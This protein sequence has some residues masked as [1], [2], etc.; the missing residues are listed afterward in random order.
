[1][2]RTHLLLMGLVLFLGCRHRPEAHQDE[3]E[4]SG[5]KKRS[6]KASGGIEYKHTLSASGLPKEM[7]FFFTDYPESEDA[8]DQKPARKKALAKL[9]ADIK[10]KKGKDPNP[11]EVGMHVLANTD[12]GFYHLTSG[13]HEFEQEG[14]IKG[15]FI[16]HINRSDD[17]D[18]NLIVTLGKDQGLKPNTRYAITGE[19]EI[20]SNTPTGAIGVGGSPDAV[21][22]R[23]S[24]TASPWSRRVEAKYW[25]TITG[26][27]LSVNPWKE[28]CKV[29][30][31]VEMGSI[32]NGLHI[33][34][35]MAFAFVHNSLTN[36]EPLIATTGE[37]GL[38]HVNF[39]SH[40]GFESLSGWL[41]SAVKIH[42]LP[43]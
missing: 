8:A 16:T 27:E 2:L 12:A 19:I 32:N 43:Q 13:Y 24:A 35:P 10:K 40:S 1:M 23:L 41:V 9:I 5:A 36:K 21:I 31:A 29:G 39:R 6:V 3:S 37:D 30:C 11:Y 18:T 17:I 33:E 7:A 42:L 15:F 14:L 34:H 4:L 20:Y 26:D 22:Y 28:D 38:L 25:R